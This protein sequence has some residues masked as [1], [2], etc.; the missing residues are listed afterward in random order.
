M[1]SATLYQSADRL[2]QLKKALPAIGTVPPNFKTTDDEG[3]QFEL[4]KTF[5]KRPKATII[6]FWHIE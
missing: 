3:N 4:Y 1:W 5:D 6:N 2:A